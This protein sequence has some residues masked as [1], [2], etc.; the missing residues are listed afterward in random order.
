MFFEIIGYFFLLSGLFAIFS[1][2]VGMM[3]FTDFFT[4]I[5]AAGVIE[6]FGVPLS[7]IGIACLAPSLSFSVKALLA[8]ILII[9]LSPV[10]THALAKAALTARKT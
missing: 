5:H 4:K 9:I 2:I 10:A 7:L 8:A 3:R 1:G 6:S